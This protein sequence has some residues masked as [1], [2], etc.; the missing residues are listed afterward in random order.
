[1]GSLNSEHG[2]VIEPIA[3]EGRRSG[4]GNAPPQVYHFDAL[5]REEKGKEKKRN[6]QEKFLSKTDQNRNWTSTR[7]KSEEVD[8]VDIFLA[9][10]EWKNVKE[11]IMQLRYLKLP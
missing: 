10:A 5:W 11:N 8:V 9:D 7:W 2:E 4:S 3:L 1:M 6:L